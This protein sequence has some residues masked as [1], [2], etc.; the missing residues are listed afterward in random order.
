MP[1]PDL[2]IADPDLLWRRILPDVNWLVRVDGELR[3]SSA[4]FRYAEISVDRE[5]LTSEA[6]FRNG[7]DGCGIAEVEAGTARGFGYTVVAD[8]E[9]DND[10]H[11]LICTPKPTKSLSRKLAQAC[12]WRG[13]PPRLPE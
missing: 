8:P 7:F 10:A 3:P 6:C 11:A 9:P 2:E 4:A 5:R 13:I 1:P 12:R